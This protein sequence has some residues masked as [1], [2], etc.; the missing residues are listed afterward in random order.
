M[1]PGT[2][3]G[4]TIRTF[5]P[6]DG[7][8]SF[9]IALSGAPPRDPVYLEVSVDGERARLFTVTD[10]PEPEPASASESSAPRERAETRGEGPGVGPRHRDSH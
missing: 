6:L 2:R 5:L 3:G 7:E 8:Y 10:K 9:H 4:T 1:P